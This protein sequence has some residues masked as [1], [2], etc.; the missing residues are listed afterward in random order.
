MEEAKSRQG[1]PVNGADLSEKNVVGVL[2][3]EQGPEEYDADIADSNNLTVVSVSFVKTSEG[4]IA[5]LPPQIEVGGAKTMQKPSASGID[6]PSLKWHKE[7]A[8]KF[9][10]DAGGLQTFHR[11]FRETPSGYAVTAPIRFTD[12]KGC[13]VGFWCDDAKRRMRDNQVYLYGVPLEVFEAWDEMEVNYQVG[14]EQKVIRLLEPG[15]VAKGN[16]GFH[17]QLDD[18]DRTVW[19]KHFADA[20][21][22]VNEKNPEPIGD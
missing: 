12:K 15:R 8:D 7:R 16:Q 20:V 4:S 19:A 10:S 22:R 6:S 21:Q 13:R 17:L 3:C 11:E 14:A 2:V 1:G 18:D 9:F 5:T